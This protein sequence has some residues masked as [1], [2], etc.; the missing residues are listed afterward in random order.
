MKT[1]VQVRLRL[2]NTVAFREGFYL[3]LNDLC[4]ILNLFS[5]LIE[6]HTVHVHLSIV[7]MVLRSLGFCRV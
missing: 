2:K 6:V 5:I 1:L 7:Y 3:V 4:S